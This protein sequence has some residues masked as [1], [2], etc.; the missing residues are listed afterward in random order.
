MSLC[1]FL[2]EAIVIETKSVLDSFS[3]INVAEY[4]FL[5][6]ARHHPVSFH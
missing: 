1:I 3:I 5:V 4:I 2:A 6:G